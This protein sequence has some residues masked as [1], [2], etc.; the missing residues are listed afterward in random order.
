VQRRQQQQQ[1]KQRSHKKKRKKQQ[2]QQQKGR[3]MKC[4]E[5]PLQ[6]QYK[7]SEVGTGERHANS[8]CL[9]NLDRYLCL[10]QVN[11]NDNVKKD[12]FS[13]TASLKFSKIKC[14]E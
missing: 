7:A 13:N 11:I 10:L 4:T 1:K 14:T 3:E 5:Q 9:Q 2:K 6:S 12:T 8:W